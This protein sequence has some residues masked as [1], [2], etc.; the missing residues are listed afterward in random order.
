M[1][2]HRWRSVLFKAADVLTFIRLLCTSL[3]ALSP[4]SLQQHPH[5]YASQFTCALPLRHC[6]NHRDSAFVL[7]SQG[8]GRVGGTNAA[9]WAPSLW[10][11]IPSEPFHCL[12]AQTL[13]TF[14]QRYTYDTI[15]TRTSNNV[16]NL[17]ETDNVHRY[18]RKV[19][20]CI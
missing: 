12:Q 11:S 2:F 4:P 13:L 20:T 19:R 15:E 6:E 17:Q 16:S 10:S 8:S 5:L 1:R 7:P 14:R 9:N 3:M 18:L